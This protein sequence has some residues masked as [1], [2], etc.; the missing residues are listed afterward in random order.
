MARAC[1][2]LASSSPAGATVCAASG[3][4][5]TKIKL[6]IDVFISVSDV[7]RLAARTD[8]LALLNSAL[9][10]FD[11]RS[12]LS[13]CARLGVVSTALP[14][15]LWSQ[16][17]AAPPK[18]TPQQVDDAATTA[19]IQL[20]AKDRDMLLEGLD[21]LR[22]EY[23]KIH[24]LHIANSVEPAI[25]FDPVLPQDRKNLVTD[26]KP[27]RVSPLAENDPALRFNPAGRAPKDLESVCFWNVRQL[28]ELVRTKRV[29][30]SD[31]TAMY[32]ERLKRLD[33]KLHCVITY[34]EERAQAQAR[35]ADR[36]VAAGK[37]RGPLHG[38]P[39][40]GKDLLS[41]KGYRT[42]WG[43]GGFEQQTFDEDATVVTRL[44]RAGAILIAKLTLG[45]LAMG[46][47]WF[48]GMTRNP[49][50]LD[51]GSSGSSAGSAAATAAG[52]VGFTLGTETLG[53]ISSPST[54]CGTTGLRPTFGLVPKTGAMALSWTMDKIGP[55]CRSVE[56]TAIVLSAIY[57]FDERDNC[58]L[59][60]AAFNWDGPVAGQSWKSLRIGYFK[61]EFELKPPSAE[62]EPKQETDLTEDQ[63]KKREQQRQMRAENYKR[64]QYDQRL[65]RKSTRLNSSHANS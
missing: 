24:A 41:V 3:S 31:L 46:D 11:R 62:A 51:Q 65:D 58:I 1:F 16:D 57:G 26:R 5:T 55:I 54:R 22:G 43:A 48:G 14:S 61:D 40:G 17:K 53:S 34:T 15:L 4:A 32:L 8:S 7:R 37:Y 47:K 60:D 64:R 13:L 2:A 18:L 56:D 42:T 23:E 6:R 38:I 30:P 36:E 44:D 52:C 19:G 28:G 35:E 25:V 45:A 49:W 20:S 50:S 39:W 63:K 12:F 9:R 33:A 27:L 59:H 29:A 10:M 21:E